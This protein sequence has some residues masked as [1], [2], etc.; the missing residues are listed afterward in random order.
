MKTYKNCIINPKTNGFYSA[1]IWLNSQY[2]KQ[3]RADTLQGI[4]EIINETLADNGI[5]KSY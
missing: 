4:K 1:R 2:T 3:V 5:K